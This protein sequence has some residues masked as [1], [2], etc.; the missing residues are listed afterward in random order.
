MES[1]KRL[2]KGCLLPKVGIPKPEIPKSGERP[3]RDDDKLR[4]ASGGSSDAT[5]NASFPLE[6]RQH[7]RN[8]D[9]TSDVTLSCCCCPSAGAD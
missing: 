6:A 9:V 1:K 4:A 2:I 3:K 8:L 5:S 7:Q